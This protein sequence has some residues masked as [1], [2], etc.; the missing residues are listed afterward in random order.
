M[1]YALTF[2]VPSVTIVDAPAAIAVR[3]SHQGSTVKGSGTAVGHSG[4]PPYLLWIAAATAGLTPTKSPGSRAS[5]S[6]RA[7]ERL[8]LEAMVG[9][10]AV[11]AAAH[12][13]GIAAGDLAPAL[14]TISAPP[15]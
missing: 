7:Y 10:V 12:A 5:R 9:D 3:M 14:E 8:G 1:V 15:R 13:A 6:S 4:G 11:G 2:P